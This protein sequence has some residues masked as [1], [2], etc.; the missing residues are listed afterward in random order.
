LVQRYLKFS[1]EDI[2]LNKKLKDQ[3]IEELNLAGGGDS[4]ME[5]E[6]QQSGEGGGFGFGESIDYDKLANMIVEKITQREQ[7][8]TEVDKD[9]KKETDVDDDPATNDKKKSSKKK[10]KK[11]EEE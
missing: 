6:E 7:I 3:E 10:N 5:G 1:S 2:K 9:D 4:E 8:I 11:S